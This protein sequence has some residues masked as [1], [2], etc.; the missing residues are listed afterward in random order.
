M[1]KIPVADAVELWW[2]NTDEGDQGAL[3]GNSVR[4]S[5]AFVSSILDAPI[6]TDMRAL[7]LLSDKGGPLAMDIHT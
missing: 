4:L 5:P 6:P 2:D 3:W 7:K 1:L